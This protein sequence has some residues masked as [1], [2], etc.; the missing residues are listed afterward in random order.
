VK[1]D[2]IPDIIDFSDGNGVVILSLEIDASMK[3]VLAQSCT[4]TGR[5][6]EEQMNHVIRLYLDGLDKSFG[7]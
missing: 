7:T 3:Y 1:P 2:D 5:T 4:D 6:L